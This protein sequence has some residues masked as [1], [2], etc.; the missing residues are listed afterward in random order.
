MEGGNHVSR[1]AALAH[2]PYGPRGLSPRRE[3]VYP[4]IIYGEIM[5]RSFLVRAVLYAGVVSLMGACASREH[6][7]CPSVGALG[8][9][10]LSPLTIVRELEGPERTSGVTC[11][12][13]FW[14]VACYV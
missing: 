1:V 8:Q 2:F 5:R 3:L 4:L 6:A 14:S 12:N 13:A 10:A 11:E 9:G 7:R